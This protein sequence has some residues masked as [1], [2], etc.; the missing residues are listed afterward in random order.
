M[1]KGRLAG[2]WDR[3]S[4]ARPSNALSVSLLLLTGCV[5]QADLP[6]PA[7]PPG[8]HNPEEGTGSEGSEGSE[9]WSPTEEAVAFKPTA[10]TLDLERR[11]QVLTG[12]GAALAWYQD[13]VLDN[14]PEG[15]FETLFPELGIDILRLRNRFER[16]EES[17]GRVDQDVEILERA[18]EALGH[19]PILLM[20]S[21]SPPAAL[22]ASGAERCRGNADCTLRK[23][24]GQFVY[25][26][27]ADYWAQSLAF[28]AEQGIVPD[29][30][31]IQNEPG[32]IPP[33][34]EGCKFLAEETDAFPGYGKALAKVHERVQA[35]DPPPKIIGP[36]VLGLHWGSFERYLSHLDQGLLD[37]A[38]H[39]LYEQGNDGVWDWRS[40]GPDSYVPH[41]RDARRATSLPLWQSEFQTDDDKGVDG[42]FET[43]SLIQHSLV[44]ED[45]SAFVYWDMV[46][47]PPG[48][49]V[50][51]RNARDYRIRDQYYSLRHFARFTDPGFVRVGGSA[52]THDIRVSAFLSPKDDQL[53]VVLVNAGASGYDVSVA[54]GEFSAGE[55]EA[56]RTVYRPGRTLA[57][58]ELAVSGDSPDVSLPARSIATLVSR[59]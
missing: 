43:A 48:G 38:A 3:V 42:G 44:N 21:W 16:S 26:E 14:G 32:F 31:S 34:W 27:F 47:A 13:R 5:G 23:E 9:V 24:G 40:P 29:Y 17:D 53:T 8:S 50:T 30:I 46:W 33:D 41:M 54:L 20:T 22:K 18:T 25:D 15:I 36:E 2:Y 57:W 59:L 6:P 51:V 11:Y 49:L 52:E 28:Y 45:V 12:F 55:R 1:P 35:L 7:E 37:V 39:H 10:V 19:P 4:L 58:E 56:Y